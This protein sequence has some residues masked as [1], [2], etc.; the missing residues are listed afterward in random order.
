[1]L[2]G[3]AVD[4]R[5]DGAGHDVLSVGGIGGEHAVVADQVEAGR[6]DESGEFLE[7]LHGRQHHMGGPVGHHRTMYIH[8]G[9][10]RIGPG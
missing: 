10:R 8:P 2:T 3:L 5:P 7:Q 9:L 4:V 1:M 6:G